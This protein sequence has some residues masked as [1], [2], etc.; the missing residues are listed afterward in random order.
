MLFCIAKRIQIGKSGESSGVTPTDFV[1]SLSALPF[2]QKAAAK[3]VER[4]ALAVR[5]LSRVRARTPHRGFEFEDRT[6]TRTAS[7]HGFGR[8]NLPKNL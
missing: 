1:Q 6:P 2:W 8:E 4:G 7:G 5:F 3:A